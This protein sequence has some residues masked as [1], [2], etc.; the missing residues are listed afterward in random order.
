M[1]E[2]FDT[3]MIFC[4]GNCP[5]NDG[6]NDTS[7]RIQYRCVK[8]GEYHFSDYRCNKVKICYVEEDEN[9]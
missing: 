4:C 5:F 3:S 6:I 8:T 2:F 1:M 7:D 9:K